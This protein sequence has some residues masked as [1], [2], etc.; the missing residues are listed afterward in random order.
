MASEDIREDAEEALVEAIT[1]LYLNTPSNRIHT[2]AFWEIIKVLGPHFGI[3][4]EECDT[5]DRLM[6]YVDNRLRPDLDSVDASGL[7]AA[8]E[9]TPP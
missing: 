2:N 7:V 3:D 1:A 9:Q 6:E 5:P 4:V 8:S